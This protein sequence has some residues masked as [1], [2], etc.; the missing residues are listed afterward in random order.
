MFKSIVANAARDKRAL[1][2][3]SEERRRGKRCLCGSVAISE[4]RE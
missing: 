2:V 3:Q 1:R 4:T